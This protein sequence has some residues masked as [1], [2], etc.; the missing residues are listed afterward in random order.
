MSGTHAGAGRHP[1]IGIVA[2][3]VEYRFGYTPARAPRIWP[4]GAP[5]KGSYFC[6]DPKTFSMASGRPSHTSSNIA[7]LS[8]SGS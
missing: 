5:A 3:P 1:A 6:A 2:R 4:G 8:R 7:A